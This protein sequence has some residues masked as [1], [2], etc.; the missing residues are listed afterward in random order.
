M[1]PNHPQ[2]LESAARYVR[3]RMSAQRAGRFEPPPSWPRGRGPTPD[4]RHR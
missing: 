1:L 2:S 4:K 3:E